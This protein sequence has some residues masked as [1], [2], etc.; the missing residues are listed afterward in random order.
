MTV[1]LDFTA[2]MGCKN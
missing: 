1:H 2:N